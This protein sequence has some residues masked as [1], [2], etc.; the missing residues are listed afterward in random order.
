MIFYL[1]TTSAWLAGFLPQS[2]TEETDSAR[3][4]LEDMD[5]LK[6]EG[7]EEEDVS[8]PDE[9]KNSYDVDG[10][11][12]GYDG[13]ERRGLDRLIDD[14]NVQPNGGGYNP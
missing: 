11:E 5:V 4:L 12:E 9:I 1:E 14:I 10:T 6:S 7:E 13:R 2:T 8:E 3:T